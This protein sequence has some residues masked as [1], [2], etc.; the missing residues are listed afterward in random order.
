MY[1][2]LYC[3]LNYKHLGKFLFPQIFYNTDCHDL[4]F[5]LCQPYRVKN[6]ISL[7]YFLSL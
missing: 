6:F 3:C 7:T 1:I 5:Y 2:R 4:C